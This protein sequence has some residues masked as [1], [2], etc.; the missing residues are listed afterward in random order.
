[1]LRSRDMEESLALL[2]ALHAS[3]RGIM[4]ARVPKAKAPS[5]VGAV[6][7]AVRL[8][9]PWEAWWPSWHS[10]AVLV[11]AAERHH[12]V[13]M[14]KMLAQVQGCSK[15]GA[16]LL[17]DL[18]GTPCELVVGLQRHSDTT[19]V[20]ML[21]EARSQAGLAPGMAGGGISGG[22]KARKRRVAQPPVSKRV[23]GVFRKLFAPHTEGVHSEEG[24]GK[25]KRK[26]VG[27]G[28]AKGKR[29]E[30]AKEEVKGA[31]DAAG[32]GG[33]DVQHVV[34]QEV[35]ALVSAASNSGVQN[36]TASGAAGCGARSDE[37]WSCLRCTLTNEP[38][39]YEC[40]V[41]GAARHEDTHEDTCHSCCS[42][43]G[44]LVCCSCCTLAFHA[45]CIV[46]P[47]AG[48]EVP[49]GEWTCPV[50]VGKG[51]GARR[52]AKRGVELLM[53]DRLIDASNGSS[54]ARRVSTK[55][56]GV[57]DGDGGSVLDLTN[58]HCTPSSFDH[59]TVQQ[60]DPTAAA[61][62]AV[63]SVAAPTGLTS[64]DAPTAADSAGARSFTND[65]LAGISP[66]R[67]RMRARCQ[68]GAGCYRTART[69]AGKEHLRIFC[70]P[71]DSDY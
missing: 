4:G 20:R 1:M 28:R 2:A 18:F 29:R 53:R 44:T 52:G 57:Q 6:G 56:D 32:D 62:A 51:R 70:H 61:P 16:T 42:N 30:K 23:V 3:I 25:R 14:A 40:S 15:I 8:P 7:G 60:P 55:E 11:T 37:A 17:S 10:Y 24:G 21:T 58:D 35:G 43:E 13:I 26:A 65:A 34:Q 59:R 41:C 22:S 5:V 46:P 50:C 31:G 66:I 47:L 38:C 69:A 48:G 39:V 71:N 12:R 64:V 54:K 63:A 45:F 36:G 33:C 27:R 19:I 9:P 67:S 68:Y 49:A